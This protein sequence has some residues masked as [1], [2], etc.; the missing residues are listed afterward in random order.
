MK[1]LYQKE[2]AILDEIQNC[3]SLKKSAE[4]F[5]QLQDIKEDINIYE[6]E[7]YR[8]E[9]NHAARVRQTFRV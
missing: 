6:R 1:N 3:T 8:E 9:S 5:R 4:L 7:R 2:A